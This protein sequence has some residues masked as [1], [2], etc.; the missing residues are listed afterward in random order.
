MDLSGLHY[1]EDDS[2]NELKSLERDSNSRLPNSK[3]VFL[4]FI[5]LIENLSY[6]PMIFLYQSFF[7]FQGYGSCGTYGLI[8][9]VLGYLASALF[10]REVFRHCGCLITMTL[11]SILILA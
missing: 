5:L 10:G 11:G 4:S 3:V 1:N 2:N 6:T 8:F 7:A 9:I